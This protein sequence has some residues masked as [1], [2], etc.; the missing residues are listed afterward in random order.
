MIG[1][2]PNFGKIKNHV[3][4]NYVTIDLPIVTF[5]FLFSNIYHTFTE[6]HLLNWPIYQKCHYENAELFFQTPIRE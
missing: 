4:Y 2:R 3:F 6:I 1:N 5:F